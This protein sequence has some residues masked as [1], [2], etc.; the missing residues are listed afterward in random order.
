[1]RLFVDGT[2]LLF[3]AFYAV[4]ELAT[5][6][7]E[8]T[9]GLYGYAATLLK[10]LDLKPSGVVVAFDTPVPTF[11]KKK[12]PEYKAKRLAPPEGLVVQIPLVQE[13]TSLLG[14]PWLALPGF[15]ADDILATLAVHHHGEEPVWIVSQDKDLLQL[16]EG[17]I[18]VWDSV[19]NVKMDSA[20]VLAR[21]GVPPKSVVDYLALVGDQSDNVPGV[22]GIGE[23]TAARLLKE[24]GSVAQIYHHLA[25]VTPERIRHLLEQNRAHAF[26]SH[27]LVTLKTDVPLPL[28]KKDLTYSGI[29]SSSDLARFLE[30]WELH[31]L[32]KRLGLTPLSEVVSHKV[33]AKWTLITT[34]AQLKEIVADARQS[35]CVALD[36]ETTGLNPFVHTLVGISLCYNEDE[37]FYI[38]L[39]HRRAGQSIADSPSP[40]SEAPERLPNQLTLAAVEHLLVPLLRDTSVEKV[41]HNAKFD[42]AV[43]IHAGL[44]QSDHAGIWRDTMIES[45]LLNP[46][47]RHSLDRLALKYLKVALTEFTDLVGKAGKPR[48]FAEV[49]LESALA[50]AAA[51]AHTT[52]VA[53][54]HM[55]PELKQRELWS[56]YD[57]IETP[58]LEVL[59]DMEERGM[60][61]NPGL[62]QR[63]NTQI[64][65]QLSTLEQQIGDLA[66]EKFNV[67]SPKQLAH[68]LFE[69]LGLPMRRRT[70]TGPSTDE[71]VLKELAPL[72]PLCL[73][74]LEYRELA[75][76]QGTYL[77]GLLKEI[78]PRTHRIHTQFNQCVTATGRLSSS[79]PNLQNI[80][81]GRGHAYD[82]RQAFEAAEGCALLAADYSQVELRL[83]A[84]L[85]DDPTLVEAFHA[86]QDIHEKTA[87]LLFGKQQIS[88]EERQIGKTVNFGIVYGQTPYGL[89]Q[90][91]SIPTTQ[92]H[93]FIEQY[94][95]NYPKVHTYMESLK[96]TAT[97]HGYCRTLLGRIRYLPNLHSRNRMQREMDER[98]AMNTPI[99]GTAADLMKKAM[100]DVYGAFLRK[101]MRS[102]LVLQV[103][104]ELIV[105]GPESEMEAVKGLVRTHMEQVYPLHVPLTVNIGIGRNWSEAERNAL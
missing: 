49:D 9:N 58:L 77:A 73:R 79:R 46:E 64:S 87:Q 100:L 18:V 23:K 60:F 69:K 42:R 19:K 41:A 104:D 98:A 7:G 40:Q 28:S 45:Y 57:S 70:K 12:F 27:D 71:S 92:A 80:P 59:G 22:K 34:E 93:F 5:L 33:Q 39:N 51:D 15:E 62:L 26:L 14:C 91:L 82:I 103:H 50:Y 84:H 36:T 32:R 75:K 78:D 30:R 11:R 72:H 97:A 47:E 61:V 65:E 68:V 24:F 74:V 13:L 95:K 52:Y 4:R 63:F 85:S 1:M 2:S 54:R 94:F 99:Q 86:N 102:R 67:Q 48:T 37:A 31:S 3:R 76:L 43:L 89:S 96:Q 35:Q 44:L 83:L 105:E 25:R 53:H 101:K 38:P 20:A 90:T 8:P 81:A 29:P 16:V 17:N 10:L 66:G 55:V 88:E 6:Q 56:L 21:L